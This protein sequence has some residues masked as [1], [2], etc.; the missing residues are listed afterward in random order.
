M[1]AMELGQLIYFFHIIVCFKFNAEIK[2]PL[3]NDCIKPSQ[4][5]TSYLEE[6]WRG[7]YHLQKRRGNHLP[8]NCQLLP[9]QIVLPIH[10]YWSKCCVLSLQS[11]IILNKTTNL[12]FIWLLL[13]DSI[14]ITVF[15]SY[16]RL[17][18]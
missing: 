10:S 1:A 15:D 17:P 6:V 14:Q 16:M 13:A 5:V 9:E 7:I 11:L 2:N 8:N 12:T 18:V 3:R 4:Q